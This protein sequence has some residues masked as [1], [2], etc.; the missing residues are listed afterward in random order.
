MPPPQV[1]LARSLQPSDFEH[2]LSAHHIRVMAQ[3]QES[4]TSHKFYLYGVKTGDALLCEA[5]LDQASASLSLVFRSMM[6]EDSA[7][8]ARLFRA[9]LEQH[10]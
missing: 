4:P 8:F 3:G 5:V 7:A 1:S 9:I 6:P 10:Q 2:L